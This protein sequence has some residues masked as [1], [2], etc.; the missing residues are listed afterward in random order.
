MTKNNFTFI[1]LFAGIG[2]F[3]IALEEQGGKCVGYSEIDKTAIQ[4]YTANFDSSE[5]ENLGDITKIKKYPYADLIT[6][7][8]PCQSWSVAG[9]KHGFEDPRGALWFDTI[10]FVENVKPKAFIFENVKG[11]AD[12]RNHENLSLI[13]ESFE[14]VGYKVNYKVLNAFDYG[15]P[16]N[17]ER[18][19]IVGIK[20]D[21]I[22]EFVF[23]DTYKILPNMSE[24]LEDYK[25]HLHKSV[26][27]DTNIK[28]SFGMSYTINK[29]NYFTFCDT[30]N[31]DHTIHSWDIIDTNDNEKNICF[32]ILKNRRKK[33]YGT[34]DGNPL[35]FTD[36]QKI[37]PNLKTNDLSSLIEKKILLYRDGKYDFVNSKNSSGVFGIYRIFTPSSHVFST[38]T[39]T[40][41]RDFV[42]TID[43]PI[44]TKD[45]KEYFVENIYRKKLY[46]QLSV[47]EAARVQGFPDSYKFPESYGKSLGLL[48]NALGVNIVR[49][50]A[51]N[52]LK[53]IK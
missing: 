43:I 12:P 20:K 33:K 48:G 49:E 16:Q 41:V 53:V 4:V 37:I 10:K 7:G 21:N 32:A 51:I 45:K 28:N 17:R 29:D 27:N 3:R 18:V 8:V 47:R 36:I 42:S 23:P 14:Q 30:R 25:T 13:I 9:K 24:I 46:R 44:N 50:V 19:F 39:K 34:K 22:L 26:K 52:L 35:S 6:G 2:G 5:E 38:L 40:G 31:G 11:L 15:L 1:D